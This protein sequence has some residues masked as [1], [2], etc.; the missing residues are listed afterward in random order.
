MAILKDITPS[1]L[2]GATITGAYHRIRQL[3]L[4]YRSDARGEDDDGFDESRSE[5]EVRFNVDIEIFANESVRNSTREQI[6]GHSYSMPMSSL[7]LVSGE[8]SFVRSAYEYL[9][10]GEGEMTGGI[11]A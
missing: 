7:S 1:M 8:D 4:N 6:G 3:E 5:T 2:G 10:T 11:D 9:K